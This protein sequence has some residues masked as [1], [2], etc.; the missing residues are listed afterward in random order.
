LSNGSGP[1]RLGGKGAQNSAATTLSHGM[2]ARAR[3]SV[4]GYLEGIQSP[5]RDAAPLPILWLPVRPAAA[6]K[7]GG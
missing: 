2:V 7:P 4:W 3:N 6:G 1:E 5:H